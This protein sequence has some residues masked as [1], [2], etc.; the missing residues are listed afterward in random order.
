MQYYVTKLDTIKT[1]GYICNGKGSKLVMYIE[2][3]LATM[4]PGVNKKDFDLSDG[5]IA[6]EL[7]ID[8][9][10]FTVTRL[11]D[12]KFEVNAVDSLDSQNGIDLTAH[13]E[14]VDEPPSGP[15][16]DDLHDAFKRPFADGI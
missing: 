16:Y 12:N 8:Q 3:V 1:R 15:D 5:E 2:E 9:F 13:L 11:K 4:R 10:K 14:V 7:D 6:N